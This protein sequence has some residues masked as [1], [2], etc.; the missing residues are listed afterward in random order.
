MSLGLADKLIEPKKR[1]NL[2]KMRQ[3]AMKKA[4]DT[5][6]LRK[7]VSSLYARINKVKVPKIE[8]NEVVKEPVDPTLTIDDKPVEIETPQPV[9]VEASQDSKD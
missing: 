5:A 6:E 4:P 1:G 3:A 8:L 7:L 2:R 9:K